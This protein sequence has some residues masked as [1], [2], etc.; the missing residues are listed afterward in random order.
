MSISDTLVESL[1]T[2]DI[3]EVQGILHH[4]CHGEDVGVQVGS[5]HLSGNKWFSKNSFYAGEYAWHFSRPSTGTRY[6]C[7]LELKTKITGVVQPEFEGE[8]GWHMFLK[9]CFPHVDSGYGLSKHFQNTLQD[10]LKVAFPEKEVTCYMTESQS[11]LLIPNCEDF[12]S[13]KHFE[14]L[15]DS[16]A[17]YRSKYKA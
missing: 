10:H 3:K 5:L 14:L 4:G 6:R 9:K 8:L 16:K 17:D 2:W 11:E 7:D 1:K 15:P 13:V 12:V